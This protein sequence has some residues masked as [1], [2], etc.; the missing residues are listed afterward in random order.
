MTVVASYI[1]RNGKRAEE[2]PLENQTFEAKDGEFAWIGLAEPTADEM[3]SL[4]MMFGLHPLAVEDALNGQQV[5]KIDIYGDPAVRGDQD[6]ASGG[7]QD[8]L[9]RNMHLCGQAS[10]DLSEAWLR[11]VA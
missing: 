11:E 1:Y 6:R 10:P 2:V 5:P 8:R 9:R 7:R 4:R 3:E